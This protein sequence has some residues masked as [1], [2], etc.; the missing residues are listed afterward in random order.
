MR[1]CTVA[2]P[3]WLHISLRLPTFV[4][5]GCQMVRYTIVVSVSWPLTVLMPISIVFLLLWPL[6]RIHQHF[7][8]ARPRSYGTYVCPISCGTLALLFALLR[9]T[10]CLNKPE[11]PRIR[12]IPR[13]GIGSFLAL[14]AAVIMGLD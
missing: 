14:A 9:T 11:L 2:K 4:A 3:G 13:R 1:M 5:R 10:A 12:C 6:L 8:W 7:A